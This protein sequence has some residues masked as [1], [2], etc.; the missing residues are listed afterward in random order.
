MLTVGIDIGSVATK[1]VLLN[2][3]EIHRIVYPTGWSPRQAGRQAYEEVLKRGACAPE[4]IGCV[5]AT[6]YGRV[7]LDFADRSVTEISCHARGAHYLRPGV[8]LV[9]DIGGQDSKVIRVNGSGRVEDFIMNDKCAA[10]TGRF[11]QVMANALGCDVD[12][13]GAMISD[14]EPAKIN[15]MCTVFAESEVIGLLAEGV[16]KELIVEGLHRSIARRVAAMAARM[17][18]PPMVVFT[19]GVARNQGVCRALEAELGV[20]VEV[21]DLCQYTGAIGAALIGRDKVRST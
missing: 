21:P 2:Q 12:E 8:S 3:T 9:I 18:Q 10:G 1:A 19:G 17:G 15:S 16:P 11:L 5:V 13:L 7:S 14:G 4:E 20:P 6:G